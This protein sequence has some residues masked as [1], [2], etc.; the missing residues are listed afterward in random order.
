LQNDSGSQ[1]DPAPRLLADKK[2]MLKAVK[3]HPTYL[4][5]VSKELAGDWDLLL[6]AMANPRIV[7]VCRN[8]LVLGGWVPPVTFAQVGANEFW[9]NASKTVQDKLKLHDVFVKLMLGGMMASIGGST[10]LTLLNRGKETSLAFTKPIAEY[11][12]VPMGEELCMLRQAVK[13]LALKGMYR[14]HSWL[15][16]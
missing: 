6:A 7:F 10:P 2:F 4:S 9:I 3:A 5:D 14:E 1:L 8:H 11:L 16:I 15:R 12:G 13:N